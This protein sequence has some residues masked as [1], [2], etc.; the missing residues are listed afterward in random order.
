MIDLQTLRTNLDAVADRLATRGFALDKAAF[1]TLEAERKDIQTR[2]QDLQN[3]RNVLSKAIVNLHFRWN[4]SFF[5]WLS[6]TNP[7][8]L[9]N[10]HS[11]GL[12]NT[13]AGA[14]TAFGPQSESAVHASV[15]QR[16]YSA[17]AG[18]AAVLGPTTRA[19]TQP[20]AGTRTF[21]V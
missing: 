4:A 14:H 2:T 13:P 21:P 12:P 6:A 1:L 20:P 10:L 18:Q 15:T 17:I 16:L 8:W 7:F 19:A 11:I 5:S 9:L 3:R